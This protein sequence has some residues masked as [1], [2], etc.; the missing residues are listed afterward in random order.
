[1]NNLNPKAQFQANKSERI[2]WAEI[3]AQPITQ[4]AFT[5]AIAQL[6]VSGITLEQMAGANALCRVVLNLSEAEPEVKPFPSKPLK[7]Y[8]E[9]PPKKK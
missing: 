8:D 7:S 6:A 9:P 5:H 3:A 1:M 4:K 2:Q